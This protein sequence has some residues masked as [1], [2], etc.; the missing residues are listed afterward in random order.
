MEND[1][2]SG[3]RRAKATNVTSLRV[4]VAG[5]LIYLGGSLIYDMI[6]GRST[7]SPFAACALGL[8]FIAAGVVFGLYSWR[9]WKILEKAAR[10]EEAREGS[11]EEDG[12][13]EGSD[14]GSEE[15]RGQAE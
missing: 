13:D 12:G 2:E 14:E 15:D 10:E 6:R 9:R 5:Y 8:L 1:K 11:G 3:R 4:V 7:L